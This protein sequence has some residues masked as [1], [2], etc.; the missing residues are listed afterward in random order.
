MS[1]VVSVIGIGLLAELV[2]EHLSELYR[3]DDRKDIYGGISPEAR[4]ILVVCDNWQSSLYLKAE[5]VLQRGDIPWLCSFVLHDEVVVG[6]LVQPGIPGCSQCADYRRHSSVEMQ[7]QY[8]LQ[9][10]NPTS[11]APET[12]LSRTGLRQAVHLLTVEVQR[13]MEGGPA[14]TERH[15]YR[16]NM[17]TL[18]CSYHSFVPNPLCPVCGRLP[19]DSP[20]AARVT[21]EPR[22]K[23]NAESYRS[24][25]ADKLKDVLVSDYFDPRTGIFDQKWSHLASPFANVS[26]HLSTIMG[27]EITG[28]R[29]HSFEESEWI[30]FLEGLERYN[31]TMP[32]GKR[33]VVHD[34]FSNLADLALDPTKVG[35]YSQEQYAIPGFPFMP[36]EPDRPID[37][38]WGYSIMHERPILVPEQLAY[39]SSGSGSGFVQE[40]SNGCALGGS[41]EEAI[42]F[43]ILE[44]VERDSFL[45]TWYAKLPVPRLDPATA[46]DPELSL[47]IERMRMV[48][49]YDIL[50]FNTMMENGIPSLWALAKNRRAAGANLICAA[51][52]H[53]DP[54]RAAKGAVH[55]LANTMLMLQ[56]TYEENRE[57]AE[58]MYRDSSLVR[59]MSDHALL[60]AL[61]EAEERLDF[62][63]VGTGQL[64]SF[65]EQFKPRAKH[66]D[67]TDDLKNI[68]RTFRRLNLDVIVVNQTSPEV[69]RNGLHCVKVLIPGMLPMAFGHQLT[70]LTGLQRV[71]DVP[72][73]LG[74][75]KQPLTK[76]QLNPYPHP[77][78]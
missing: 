31:G 48:S 75:V 7:E 61:P 23:P 33:S 52:A 16:V 35:V 6:P 64:R 71:F 43:G 73:Q 69:S 58:Q 39:Y 67:L 77:F 4:L 3:M 32:R 26:V 12:F 50:L 21:L 40:T 34:S 57:E 5:E 10:M 66:V 28:G 29:T 37:W 42:L 25:S 47:M 41:L 51:G 22:L 38:V 62:L 65:D 15:L 55:E 54:I 74:Y 44:V 63:L 76:E 72:A 1:A 24:R 13:V 45:M 36:Y 27:E 18:K 53:L 70:R 56:A 60:Y 59:Q 20:E 49:G 14:A 46:N 17:D 78:P 11:K 2:R 8:M 19:D 68:L 30:A 9:L